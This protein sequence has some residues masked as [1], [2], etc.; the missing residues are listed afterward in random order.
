MNN[1]AVRD[2]GM[3][4]VHDAP[5][6]LSLPKVFDAVMRACNVSYAA[7]LPGAGR[8]GVSRSLA[9]LHEVTAT[10]SSSAALAGW[11]PRPAK[12]M[13]DALIMAVLALSPAAAATFGPAQQRRVFT[14]RAG[15]ASS[16]VLGGLASR[17]RGI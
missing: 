11:S 15:D 10:R 4:I 14:I 1:G 16:M 6:D 9:R 17:D 13:R 12:P 2:F 8:P 7:G 5:V 3:N